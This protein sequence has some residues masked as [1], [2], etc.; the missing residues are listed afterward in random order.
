MNK[1]EG[2]D[3]LN[4]ESLIDYLKRTNKL[5]DIPDDPK[6]KELS[7]DELLELIINKDKWLQGGPDPDLED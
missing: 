6:L 4:G 5:K 2:T 1:V 3:H 7:A